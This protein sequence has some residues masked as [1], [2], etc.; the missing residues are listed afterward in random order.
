MLTLSDGDGQYV[1]RGEMLKKHM[2]TSDNSFTVG[3]V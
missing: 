3:D 2:N 1:H